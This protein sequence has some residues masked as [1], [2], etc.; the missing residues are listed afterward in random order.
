[1]HCSWCRLLFTALRN[2][3]VLPDLE[4]NTA[5]TLSNV[6]FTVDQIATT[7]ITTTIS[8]PASSTDIPAWYWLTVALCFCLLG[9]T[10][11]SVYYGYMKAR[12]AKNK[13]Q[14]EENLL[15]D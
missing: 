8:V 9:L 2:T 5:D 7:V 12:K 3:T 10:I 6:R 14:G 1:M 11:A 4:S 13:P 15:A